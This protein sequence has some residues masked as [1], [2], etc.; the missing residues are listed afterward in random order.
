[1]G[2][3]GSAAKKRL[4]LDSEIVTHTQGKTPPS[5]RP[6]EAVPVETKETQEKEPPGELSKPVEELQE[7]VIHPHIEEVQAERTFDVRG[8]MDALPE[9]PAKAHSPEFS[10]VRV[11]EYRMQVQVA[12]DGPDLLQEEMLSSIEA[13]PMSPP[14]K[15]PRKLELSAREDEGWKPDLKPVLSTHMEDSPP[16]EELFQS[17][18]DTSQEHSQPPVSKSVLPETCQSPEI[19]RG[20]VVGEESLDEEVLRSIEGLPI[21]PPRRQPGKLDL[22]ESAGHDLDSLLNLMD[23]K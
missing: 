10:P 7:A 13:A 4:A 15:K 2:S 19:G 14:M 23:S 11:E 5:P 22:T 20:K 21:S 9:A 8:S 17:F 16:Q 18:K 12:P 1:M 3:G 6:A